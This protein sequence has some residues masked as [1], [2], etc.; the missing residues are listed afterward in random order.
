MSR[1][2]LCI[3]C[4]QAPLAKERQC[5]CGGDFE[6]FASD[7]EARRF[8][9][10]FLMEKS[11]KIFALKCHPAYPLNVRTNDNSLV[12]SVGKY[13]ASFSYVKAA[14]STLKERINFSAG[15]ANAGAIEDVKPHKLIKNKCGEHV[16]KP[17]ITPYAALRI[18]LFE[19]LYGIKIKLVG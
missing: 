10:L 2:S 1:P 4:A 11:G 12:V 6:R 15:G 17:I 19:A 14:P 8:M 18:K 7:A 3:R 5:L 16:L 9:E 13:I